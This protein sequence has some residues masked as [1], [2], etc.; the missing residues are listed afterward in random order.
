VGG[1]AALRVHRDSQ[2]TNTRNAS[3]TAHNHFINPNGRFNSAL[4]IDVN[5]QVI[6]IVFEQI[7][8][9]GARV[10]PMG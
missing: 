7:G 10:I 5:D 1:G 2:F 3:N 6:G 9:A 8:A 4:I